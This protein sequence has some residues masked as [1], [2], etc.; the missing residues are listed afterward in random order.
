[1]SLG[2]WF[3]RHAQSAIGALGTLSRNPVA[4]ALTVTV[5]GIALALPATLGVLVQSGRSLA[6]GWADVRDFSAYLAPGVALDQAESL[7]SELRSKP[8]VA[9][10]RL[11]PAEAAAAEKSLQNRMTHTLWTVVREL[12]W[13]SGAPGDWMR[14]YSI[15]TKCYKSC[16]SRARGFAAIWRRRVVP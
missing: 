3:A 7:A 2:N 16:V 11:I 10:V 4:T 13:I 15:V 12:E 6:G 9:S 8:G 5:I 1:M 14:R